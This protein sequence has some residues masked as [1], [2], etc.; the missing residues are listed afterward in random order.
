MVV[1]TLATLGAATAVDPA[2]VADL[3][4]D[5][6]AALTY[7][8]NW[9][10]IIDNQSYFAAADGPSALE[11][12]WSLSIEEQF[13]LVFPLV[14][15]WVLARRRPGVRVAIVLF[16]VVL[17]TVLRFAW[18]EPGTDPSSIYFSTVTR[19]AG[20]LAGVFLGLFWVP[21]RL[22]PREGRVAPRVL[23]LVALSGLAVIVWYAVTVDEQDP[24][25]F[26][27]S[28]T[29]VQVATLA[30]IAA[31]VVPGPSLVARGLGLA[32]LRWVGQRSYGIY[33]IHWPVIVFTARAPG[34]Q[35]EP[36]WKVAAQ[37]VAVG[38][39]AAIS[40]KLIEEPIRKDGLTDSARRLRRGFDR[41]VAGRPL[42]ASGVLAVAV[43][44]LGGTYAVAADVVTAERPAAPHAKSVV[45]SATNVPATATT[46][47][48]PTTAPP[49]APTTAAPAPITTAP[50]PPAAF[51]PT[52]AIGDSVMVGGA[53]ALAARMG[54]SLSLDAEIGRQ[55]N[56]APGI[57]RSLADAGQLAD[58][59]VLHLGN[60]G[61]FTDPEID[62]VLSI[63]GPDRRVVLVNVFV[64]RRWEGE[65]NDRLRAAAARHP[66][67]RI[68]DWRSLPASNPAL[69]A[70]DGYHLSTEGAQRYAEVV[71]AAVT[72]G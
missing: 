15:A 71:A 23:D 9:R 69:L 22:R 4:S 34:Q 54:P 50:P 33:L 57:L 61:P 47:P 39:L 72:A 63:I 65:V 66:N 67:V 10:L 16:G 28:F 14:A 40:Y 70:E 6:L 8:L 55:M 52:T 3:R 2:R 13:Y 42:V 53:D 1:V 46:A 62:E 41:V 29:L 43:V 7:H 48:A 30:T 60:N 12:L 37:V 31:V 21:R 32:P 64:P 26:R 24:S 17:S 5:A 27:G 19:A 25:A 20:L 44:A 58:T 45:I 56:E 38:V 59:V 36:V 68:A 49:V 51:P 35:P 18:H 11:H